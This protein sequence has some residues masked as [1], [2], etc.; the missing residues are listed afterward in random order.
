MIEDKEKN[1]NGFGGQEKNNNGFGGLGGF[2]RR[3]LRR[4][5]KSYD[6]RRSLKKEP[7]KPMMPKKNFEI[8]YHDHEKVDGISYRGEFSKRSSPNF[9]S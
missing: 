2:V 7:L 1:N 6:P 3:S 4:S 8:V 5:G 9:T